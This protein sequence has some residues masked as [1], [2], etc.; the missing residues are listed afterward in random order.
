MKK[1]VPKRSGAASTKSRKLAPAAA[2]HAALLADLRT[3]IQSARQRIATVANTAYTQLCWQVGRRL[4]RENLQAGRAAYG[5][6]ILATASQELTAEFGAG[7]SYTALTRMARFAEWVTDDHILASLSQELSWSHFIELLP[8]KDPLAR[9][10]YAEMCRIERWD[11]RTLR[12]KIGGMLFQRTALSRKPKSVIA[13]ELAQLRDGKMTPDLVFRDPYL[14]DL[15]GLTGAYSERDFESAILREIEGVLLELG[16]GFAFVARQKRMSV[17][18]DD[19]HLDLLFFHRHLRRLIAVELKMEAFQ[20]AHVG[21]MELYLRWLD[22]H[23]R[24]FGEEAPIGLILC[25]SADAE[26][27]ELLQL[28]ARSIRVSEYLTEL[29]P[30]PLLRARLHQAIEHAREQAVRRLPNPEGRR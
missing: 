14:L 24:A 15:L 21:Q 16:T 20:P 26:Q 27:V 11:V 23:E 17:G 30:L 6:Q 1:N 13:L 5:K 22:K 9:D 4:L 28:N 8:I 3:L 12:R 29:P 2:T 7:F 10:F 25:A 18:K 19:F